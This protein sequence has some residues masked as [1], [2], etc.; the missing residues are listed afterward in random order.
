M[1]IYQAAGQG[2]IGSM[3]AALERGCDVNVPDKD[4]RPPLCYALLLAAKA[5]NN[6]GLRLVNFLLAETVAD[7]NCRIKIN[8]P[9]AKQ[10]ETPLT[11]AA[12]KGNL[13]VLATL[14]DHPN[15]SLKECSPQS[16][17]TERGR[18]LVRRLCFEASDNLWIDTRDTCLVTAFENV[19]QFGDSDIVKQVISVVFGAAGSLILPL[20]IRAKEADGLKWILNYDSVSSSNPPPRLWVLLCDSLQ[21]NF[22]LQALEL[23]TRVAELFVEKKIWNGAILNCLYAGNFSFVKQF[24]YPFHER[25][26]KRVVE[27]TLIGLPAASTDQSLM[28]QWAD[29]GWANVA[30]WSAIHFGLW[31][32]PSFKN[33]LFDPSVDLNSSDPDPTSLEMSETGNIPHAYFDDLT[34]EGTQLPIRPPVSNMPPYY[35]HKALQDWQM[36]V[37]LLEQQNNRRLLMTRQ[38]RAAKCPLSWAVA[39]RNSQLV[40]TLLLSPRL[41]INAQDSCRRTPLM[42][43]IAVAHMHIVERILGHG[44][45]DVNMQDSK[46]RTAIFYAV[47]GRNLRI[48][49]LLVGTQRVDF[50]IRNF[51]G[52]SVHDLAKG[53]GDNDIMAALV[54]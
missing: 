22:D 39:R 48:L 9:S 36:Q 17:S 2:D 6:A 34:S 15:I 14:L 37:M 50:S 28:K 26:S 53:N 27:E 10:C 29:Q 12:E 25:P 3:K 5:D 49:K 32:N 8:R 52:Q 38:N 11:A 20:L 47:Q 45:T 18:I 46:G 42:Y 23:F 54:H 7:V 43:A 51:T 24:F 1:D 30:L 13:E 40:D 16:I 33:I 41:N 4:G 35:Q 19:L 21:R 44:D 31:Q